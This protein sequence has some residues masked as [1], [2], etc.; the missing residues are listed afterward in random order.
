MKHRLELRILLVTKT[1][2]ANKCKDQELNP[3][4]DQESTHQQRKALTSWEGLL[5]AYV[6][7]LD[8]FL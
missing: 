3:K 5:L 2:S 4:S 7:I 1:E 8:H 6:I